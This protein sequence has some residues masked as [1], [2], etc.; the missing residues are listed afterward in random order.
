[1]SEALRARRILGDYQRFQTTRNT[2]HIARLGKLV[3]ASE[4][5]SVR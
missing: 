3:T 4:A 5:A 1:M 2:K